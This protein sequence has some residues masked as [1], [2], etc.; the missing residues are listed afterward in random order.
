MS[1]SILLSTLRARVISDDSRP[2]EAG[3]RGSNSSSRS[4]A[5]ARARDRE[6]GL[7]R[8]TCE[9]FSFASTRKRSP[10][11][12]LSPSPVILSFP[13][14]SFHHVSLSVSPVLLLSF[15]VSLQHFLSLDVANRA[16]TS[17]TVAVA[18]ATHSAVLHVVALVRNFVSLH[19]SLRISFLL[20]PFSLSFLSQFL[21][22][23][24]ASHEQLSTLPRTRL[25]PC[26][27]YVINTF[28]LLALSEHD[29]SSLGLRSCLG[30]PLRALE[31]ASLV[32]FLIVA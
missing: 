22:M 3:S 27:H 11:F 29:S 15:C 24:T 31:L 16:Q 10:S 20:L 13:H 28:T 19:S 25:L 32:S 12:S 30:T 18:T 2:L 8:E 9:F 5:R 4:R 17:L 7:S 6:K 14:L 1:S 26:A 21:L 23:H